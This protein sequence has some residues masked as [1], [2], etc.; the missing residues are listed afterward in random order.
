M[1]TSGCSTSASP[2]SSPPTTTLSTPLGRMLGGELGELERRDRRRLGRLEH[3]RVAGRQRRADL[4]DG[5]HQRVVPR[6]DLADDAD[7]LAADD[8]RVALEVLAGGLALH[9]ARGAREE[10]QVVDHERDLVG[11]ERLDRL[12]GVRRPR[13]AAISSAC[14]SIASASLQQRERALARRGRRPAVEGACARRRPRGRRR[15]AGRAAPAAISSPVAGLRTGLGRALG[16]VDELAVDEVLQRAHG[17]GCIMRSDVPPR[18][19]RR[20]APASPPRRER[21]SVT[22]VVITSAARTAIGS[23]GKS[24]KDVPPTELGAIAATAAIERAGIEPGAGRPRRLRQRDP[25][26]AGRHVHGA[27][28]RD[29][30]RRS[31]RRRRRS[32]STACAAPACRRSSRPRRRSR[33]ATRDVAL[34]GGAES[35][36]R[37]PYWMP[38]ARWGAKMGAAKMVDPVMGGL[39]DPF[40]EILMGVTAENLAERHRSRASDQDAFAVESHRRAA[41]AQEAGPLRRR[42]RRASP[43]KVKRDDRRLRARR[44]HPPRRAT[45]SRWPSCRPSSRRR[46]ARSP[47]ATRRA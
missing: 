19:P 25:H 4:P 18:T 12:A 37:G 22:N 7:R 15:R 24:L 1:S 21:R 16:R 11:L 42:D 8:R 3:D 36:S 20:P 38:D 30:G 45:R 47:P 13:A 2:A 39:T 10:A 46:A 14:S 27:R 34:A 9:A 43:V 41:A 33:P 44:A 31:R 26:R 35:M 6:R 17:G 23:Y 40:H 32:P 28:R 5:H 29:E